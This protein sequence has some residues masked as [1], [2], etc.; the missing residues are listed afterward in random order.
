MCA[1]YFCKSDEF[2]AG[3]CAEHLFDGLRA[4]GLLVVRS[5]QWHLHQ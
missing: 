5:V 3:V 1:L 2:H 4:A